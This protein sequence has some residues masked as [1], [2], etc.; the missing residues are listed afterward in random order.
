MPKCFVAIWIGG[1]EIRGNREKARYATEN[2]LPWSPEYPL[3][4]K[5]FEDNLNRPFHCALQS[6]AEKGCG[7]GCRR[8]NTSRLIVHILRISAIRDLFSTRLRF[9][10]PKLLNIFRN[11]NRVT[12]NF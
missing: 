2:K 11:S 6:G 8:R 3:F 4:K 7:K 10:S 12:S 1:T 9:G 5:C